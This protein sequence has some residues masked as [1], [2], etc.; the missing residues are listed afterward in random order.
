MFSQPQERKPHQSPEELAGTV[1]TR[2]LRTKGC[3]WRKL[4][5]QRVL[6]PRSLE[7]PEVGKEG[8]ESETGFSAATVPAASRMTTAAA[9]AIAGNKAIT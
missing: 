3:E 7:E 6:P 2:V 5:R 8:R 9:A 4:P 1:Q